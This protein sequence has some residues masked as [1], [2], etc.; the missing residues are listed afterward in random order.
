MSDTAKELANVTIIV[1]SILKTDLEARDNDDYLYCKVCERFNA[2]SVNEP[3][4]KVLLNRKDLGYPPFETV[5]RSRQK[6]QETYPELA[7]SNKRQ[8]LQNTG[9]Y[10]SY[11]KSE[12]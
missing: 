7:G 6:L 11:A 8:R 4:S 3:F 2:V 12:V 5:R 9:A 1:K 10:K